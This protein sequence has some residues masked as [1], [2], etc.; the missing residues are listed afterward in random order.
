[1]LIKANV[2][3]M[4]ARDFGI[5]NPDS[6]N[7]EEKKLAIAIKSLLEKAADWDNFEVEEDEELDVDDRMD[8]E[9]EDLDDNELGGPENSVR[10]GDAFV[11]VEQVQ[12]AIE[13]YRQPTK[14]SRSLASM[15]SKYRWLASEYELRKLRSFER[16][17]NLS[18]FSLI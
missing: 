2:V 6:K 11:P 15:N 18:Y 5:G 4:L 17:G 12:A 16:D 14:G 9:E 7:R 3:A 8:S 1:M 10:F 13:F